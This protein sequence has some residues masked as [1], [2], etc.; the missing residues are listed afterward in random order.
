VAGQVVKGL[1]G[2]SSQKFWEGVG[3]PG[4]EER[5]ESDQESKSYD[6]D[7]SANVVS[8]AE[9]GKMSHLSHQRTFNSSYFNLRLFHAIMTRILDVVVWGVQKK[10]LVTSLI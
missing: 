7:V 6:S 8:E 5:E 3:D 4:V 10:R 9:E 1:V 2:L